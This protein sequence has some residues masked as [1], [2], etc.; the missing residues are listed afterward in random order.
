MR[1]AE[2][3]REALWAAGW[4]RDA[5]IET[6]RLVTAAFVVTD[7]ETLPF[8]MFYRDELEKQI[9]QESLEAIV[10]QL[11]PRAVVMVCRSWVATASVGARP[12]SALVSSPSLD[13]F[14]IE[15]G[16]AKPA[17]A[18]DA[19][20]VVAV[21]RKAGVIVTVAYQEADDAGERLR[22][23]PPRVDPAD[24]GHLS[25]RLWPDDEVPATSR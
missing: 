11:R 24:L 7:C 20:S 6:G 16:D 1:F 10:R 13:V 17:A 25:K 12:S 23:E 22:F 5:M 15:P 14:A 21:S 19:F 3:K 4:A 9:C 18:M 8:A 2:L